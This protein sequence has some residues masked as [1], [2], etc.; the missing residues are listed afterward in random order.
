[1][2]D[3]AASDLSASSRHKTAA[4]L[5]RPAADL[6]LS[7]RELVKEFGGNRAVAGASFEVRRGSITALIGP[8]GAGK[9]TCFNCIAGALRPD[10]G[11]VIF[12]GQEITGLPPHRIF[13]RALVRTFQI[14]QELG[15]LSVV[16]N[17]MLARSGQLGERIWETWL[18][19]G[20]VRAEEQALEREAHQMLEW[21]ELG[22]LAHE[23]ADSLSG[24]QRKLLE[25][26][27][28]L[29]GHPRLVLLDEP[30]AGVNPTLVQGLLQHIRSARDRDG[31]SFLLITHD[32]DVVEQLSDEVVVMTGGQV[33]LTGEPGPVL[34]DQRVQEAYLG[35]Q[36]R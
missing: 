15:R 16:E 22:H 28:A 6:I 12:E 13:D 2:R 36:H 26:A 9:T 17:L 23:P 7:V 5:S 3:L 11:E 4:T 33:L 30:S 19:P 8:N 32:M 34:S 14:P 20:R 10:A 1:M 27:R 24:G 21:V 25:L 31:V 18:R 29:F 35:S